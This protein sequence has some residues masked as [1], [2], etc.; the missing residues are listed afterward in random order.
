MYWDGLLYPICHP[1][2]KAKLDTVLKVPLQKSTVRGPM[3]RRE[4]VRSK[5]DLTTDERDIGILGRL[6]NS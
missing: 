5:V 3:Q 2:V 1:P 4:K 6:E